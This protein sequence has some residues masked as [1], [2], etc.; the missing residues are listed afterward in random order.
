MPT[1]AKNQER[2]AQILRMKNEG[3]SVD[4]IAE[5]GSMIKRPAVRKLLG[6]VEKGG[7][8]ARDRVNSLDTLATTN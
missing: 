1:M 7:I 6:H 8:P 4:K 5:A 2:V 3:A